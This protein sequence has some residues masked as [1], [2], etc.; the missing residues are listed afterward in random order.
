MSLTPRTV[1]LPIPVQSVL[2]SFLLT[3]LHNAYPPTPHPPSLSCIS[4]HV[5]SQL[6]SA[7]LGHRYAPIY[8][9]DEQIFLG[10]AVG[11]EAT[12]VKY[13]GTGSFG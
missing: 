6:H 7:H 4:K 1:G 13:G 11:G 12:A 10:G 3:T 2:S 8:P 5:L 9:Q